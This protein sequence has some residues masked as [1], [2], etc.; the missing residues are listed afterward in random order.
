M[1]V[2][3]GFN[4]T[5]PSRLSSLA[6]PQDEEAIRSGM[7]IVKS[8]GMVNGANTPGT[9]RK[10]Q[11][12]DAPA[13]ASEALSFYMALHDQD[14]HD[15][16][17]AG[18]LVGLDC[19]DNYEII[20]GYFDPAIVWAIDMPLTVGDDGVVTE[21]AEGD[22]IIGYITQVGNGTNNAIPYVGKTPSAVNAL[23]IRFKT[24][25]NGQSVAVVA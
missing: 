18:G 25:R 15:V 16:Q 3:R 17:A 12:A 22:V 1:Q 24:A 6:A 8:T 19:S 5:E 4:P 14:G 7:V 21:A 2:P 13:T 20:T 23:T 9:F 10:A 11:S